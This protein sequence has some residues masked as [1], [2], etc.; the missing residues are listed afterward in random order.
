MKRQIFQLGLITTLVFTLF[1]CQRSPSGSTA[2]GVNSQAPDFSLQD[3]D[4]KGVTLSQFKGK[5]VILDFW[6]T[7]CPPC[8][9]EIPHFVDLY[10]KYQD[11]GLVVVGVALDDEGAKVVKPFVEE[12]KINYPLALGGPQAPGGPEAQH[13]YGGIQGIPTTFII[14]KTGKIVDTF[15][16]SREADVF[17]KKIQPL[18]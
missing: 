10:K 15:V 5:V 18:L 9:R 12:Y 16:G 17:E 6:A 8:R 3:L 13:A 1:G 14:D 11:K 7:W 4:G 2:A